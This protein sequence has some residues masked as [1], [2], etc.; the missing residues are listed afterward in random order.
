MCMPPSKRITISATTPIRS[1]V[2]IDSARASDG[3]RSE[4]GRRGEEERRRG[5]GAAGSSCVA[6]SAS[7]KPAGD[8][9][10]IAPNSAISFIGGDANVS[11]GP[12]PRDRARGLARLVLTLFLRATQRREPRPPI[13]CMPMR[14]LLVIPGLCAPRDPGGRGGPAATAGDGSL[15]VRDGHGHRPAQ[16]FSGVVLGRISTRAR[17]SIVDPNRDDCDSAARVRGTRTTSQEPRRPD[18]YRPRTC[19]SG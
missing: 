18:V 17:S 7:T 5:D 1:T 13:L 3:K 19:A 8:D 10:Q 6:K 4:H 14:R 2:R 11:S 16:R 9:E 12:A 15:A